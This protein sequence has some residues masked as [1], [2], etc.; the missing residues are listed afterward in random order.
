MLASQSVASFC[1]A[2]SHPPWPLS[3]SGP[4]PASALAKRQVWLSPLLTAF[5]VLHHHQGKVLAF[6]FA[7]QPLVIW[8][9]FLSGHR[10]LQ[11]YRTICCST[12]SPLS[13]VFS[14]LTPGLPAPRIPTL[15][16]KHVVK[17]RLLLGAVPPAARFRYPSLV[18]LRPGP[19]SGA[20]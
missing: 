16:S 15:P 20:V 9:V 10:P 12:P 4:P 1:A 18:P 7:H 2:S 8:P 3:A 19:P 14:A 17:H 11:L 5:L 6:S 13:L